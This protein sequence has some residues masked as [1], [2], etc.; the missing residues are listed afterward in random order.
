MKPSLQQVRGLIDLATV[1]NWNVI[2]MRVPPSVELPEDINIRAISV[3]LPK[4]TTTKLAVDL[5]MGMRIQIP[6]DYYYDNQIQLGL[7][8]TVDASVLNFIS[9]WRAYCKRVPKTTIINDTI[10]ILQL[11]D[12]QLEPFYT[13][14][15]YG[16]FLESYDYGGS[17]SDGSEVLRPVL[18]ISYDYFE[19]N[20]PE[21]EWL[22]GSEIRSY[23]E[24]ISELMMRFLAF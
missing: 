16:C 12:R 11:L 2:F 3:E 6:G 21:F 15:L 1:Y 20:Y 4:S 10:I 9:S 13:F 17:L 7:V 5:P 24:K 19:E 14:T 18:T 22:P 23:F 8:E